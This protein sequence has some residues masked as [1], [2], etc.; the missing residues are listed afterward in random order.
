MQQNA[1]Y[2]DV[3][4]TFEDLLP[5]YCYAVKTNSRTIRSQLWQ[6]T[7]AGKGG[8][9]SE[10][11]AHHY[12]TL[13]SVN[14]TLVQYE[15]HTGKKN[16]HCKNQIKWSELWCRLQVFSRNIWFLIP[17]S[18]VEMPVLPPCGRPCDHWLLYIRLHK[19]ASS[20]NEK[21]KRFWLIVS[22]SE[23]LTSLAIK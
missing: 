9:M 22:I 2:R 20:S 5:C 12:M 13:I 21:K 6:P 18:R 17:I 11:K 19:Q 15:F 7:S 3:K 10:L 23:F 1:Y 16:C 8:Y 4:W 14:L